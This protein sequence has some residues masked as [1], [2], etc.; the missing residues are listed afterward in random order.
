MSVTGKG[1]RGRYLGDDAREVIAYDRE[2]TKSFFDNALE[3][4]HFFGLAEG[5]RGSLRYRINFL[6]K[7]VVCSVILGEIERQ[8]RH[9]GGRGI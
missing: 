7:F 1:A 2:T 4:F 6:L 5:D 9:S 8:H 3:I